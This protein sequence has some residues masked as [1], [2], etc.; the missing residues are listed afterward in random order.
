VSRFDRL[1]IDPPRSE[2][3]AALREAQRTAPGG[4]RWTGQKGGLT[5]IL[6]PIDGVPDGQDE[7]RVHI[8]CAAEVGVAWWR[9][10]LGRRHVRV[11]AWRNVPLWH[12]DTP[13]SALAAVYPEQTLTHVA[14]G[15]RVFVLCTCGAWGEPA[16]LA[17]MGDVCGPCHDRLAAGQTPPAAWPL[18]APGSARAVAVEPGGWSLAAMHD[19][20]S[21]GVWDLVSGRQTARFSVGRDRSLLFLAPGGRFVAL[22]C[23]DLRRRGVEV[24]ETATGK[25]LTRLRLALTPSALAAD[26]TLYAHRGDGVVS[27]PAGDKVWR[28]RSAGGLPALALS[29]AGDR[30][31][32]LAA[33]PYAAWLMDAASGQAVG[34]RPLPG[35]PCSLPAFAASGGLYV[36][37]VPRGRRRVTLVEALSGRDVAEVSWPWPSAI[38]D[39]ELS[40]R[41]DGRAVAAEAGAELRVWPLRDA[42]GAA[43]FAGHFEATH[44]SHQAFLPDGRLLR[45]DWSSGRIYLWP[46]ELFGGGAP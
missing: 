28:L 15:W 46:A 23:S 25:V 30:L 38:R 33:R 37:A 6:G 1:L 20:G 41:P 43:P 29:P 36:A 17:W 45:F 8:G 5:T 14:G 19:N 24:W 2:V 11:R 34:T 12:Y 22:H 4:L 26:G 13:R 9:D 39:V 10:F 32:H 44:T 21:V 35:R 16:A 3:E 18:A 7:W 40:P 31:A 27:C 42:A